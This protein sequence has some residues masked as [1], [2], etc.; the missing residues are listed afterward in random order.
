MFAIGGNII[1][2]ENSI[3]V[4]TLPIGYRPVSTV[5]LHCGIGNRTEFTAY[6]TVENT[7]VV[8]L[9]NPQ[10]TGYAGF[11]GYVSFVIG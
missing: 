10:V 1:P 6:V 3:T 8:K 5:I 4:G 11:T 7:G 2:A 9:N